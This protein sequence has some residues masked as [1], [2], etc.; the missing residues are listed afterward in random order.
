MFMGDIKTIGQWERVRLRWALAAHVAPYL[1]WVGVIVLLQ[2]AEKFTEVPRIA[3]AWSYAAKT[4]VCGALLLWLRPWLYDKGKNTCAT[5]LPLAI[6]VGVAVAVLW[7]LPETPWVA[8]HWPGFHAFYN[9]WLIMM[10]GQMPSYYDAFFFP[11]PP[12]SHP[13]LAYSPEV[14]GW[15]LTIMKLIGTTLVI[16]TAEEYFFRGFL[17]R[18]LRESNF[19]KV[20]PRVYDAPVFWVV[21]LVFA[22]EHDRWLGG[23]MA[24]AAY[25]W[26]AVRTGS[27]RPAVVA[28]ALTN[29]LLGVYVV[30][31]KQYGFW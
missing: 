29:F 27:V 21:V 23:A 28:H 20:S 7:V 8:A 15:G 1:V 30:L 25:G 22:V 17:Y 4:V 14:C 13:S 10:P 6:L 5:F 19:V 31:S 11:S 26:L 18:W 16:A 24:G 2:A 12:P 3:L 9:T